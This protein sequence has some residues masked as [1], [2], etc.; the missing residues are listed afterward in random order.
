MELE[1]L[2]PLACMHLSLTPYIWGVAMGSACSSFGGIA[3]VCGAELWRR[4]EPDSIKVHSDFAEMRILVPSIQVRG[5]VSD[6][7]SHGLNPG[8][9]SVLGV[10]PSTCFSGLAGGDVHRWLP[11]ILLTTTRYPYA[12]NTRYLRHAT[13][14]A[15]RPVAIADELPTGMGLDHDLKSSMISTTSEH[16]SY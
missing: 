5:C 8:H 14:A 6:R 2:L 16:L 15:R 13:F 10:L 4:R 3:T 1:H 12:R 9:L 11:V 7:L